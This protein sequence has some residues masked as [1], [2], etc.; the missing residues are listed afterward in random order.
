MRTRTTRPPPASIRAWAALAVRYT[1]TSCPFSDGFTAP[2]NVR[3]SA[4]PVDRHSVSARAAPTGVAATTV[5]S[6]PSGPR[7]FRRLTPS[8][9]LRQADGP[10]R[11]V[12]MAVEL[13]LEQVPQRH[14]P[15]GPDIA[16]HTVDTRRERPPNRPAIRL[17]SRSSPMN[18]PTSLGVLFLTRQPDVGRELFPETIDLDLELAAGS[19]A[20]LTSSSRLDLA[21]VTSASRLACPCS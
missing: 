13:P 15:E 18:A 6:P 9:P 5:N 4:R 12:R 16:H 19:T 2:E 20:A 14:R 21:A 7:A 1:A 8:A 17:D 11:R 3:C 10:A